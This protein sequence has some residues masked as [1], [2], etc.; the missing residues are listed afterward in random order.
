LVLVIGVLLGLFG[1]TMAVAAPPAFATTIEGMT[2]TTMPVECA[3]MMK[4]TSE[5][6]LP[7]NGM[8]LACIAGLGCL[9]TF[10]PEV[11]Q[12]SIGHAPARA[13]PP[14]SALLRVLLGRSV[15]PE[16]HPPATLA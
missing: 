15:Q 12:T 11:T 10:M 9:A 14:A 16:P 6:S 7:C 4:H 8:T 1:Q 3:G 13:L 5:S 2:A